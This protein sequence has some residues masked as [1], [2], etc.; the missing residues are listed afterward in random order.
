M[1]IYDEMYDCYICP[2]NEIL[3]YST[4]HRDGYKEYKSD[5]TK[6]EKCPR[7]NKCTSSKNHTKRVTRH[8]WEEY[9]EQ[10]E[11]IR[12]TIGSQEIYSS[13]SQTIERVFADA[14]EK[15]GMR[16]T[17][18]RGLAKVKME[19]TLLFACMNLKKLANW[20]YIQG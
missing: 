14:K 15:H 12:H 9:M 8:V 11:E 5:K 2:E 17:Q 19:L 6:C 7:L 1:D 13:R 18:Y 16:Y 3:K 4:T 20:K 10:V